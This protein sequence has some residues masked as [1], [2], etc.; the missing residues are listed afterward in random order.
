V[1]LALEVAR[2]GTGDPST[3]K[4]GRSDERMLTSL[5]IENFKGIAARQRIEFAPRHAMSFMRSCAVR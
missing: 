3:I 2:N 1:H 5:E 4:A